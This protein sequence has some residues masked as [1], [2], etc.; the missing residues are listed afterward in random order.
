MAVGAWLSQLQL[1]FHAA[2]AHEAPAAKG[3][4]NGEDSKSREECAQPP[5]TVP[6]QTGK[7]RNQQ[8]QSENQP[9]DTAASIDVWGE[10]SCHAF[11]LAQNF[12]RSEVLP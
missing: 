4:V 6:Q 1:C 12:N 7:G 9:G 11:K 5:G 8:N 2:G 3:F 10:E